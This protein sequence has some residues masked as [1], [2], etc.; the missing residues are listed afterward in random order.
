MIY[1]YS[2]YKTILDKSLTII[3]ISFLVLEKKWI[4]FE[5]IK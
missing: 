2:Y 1:R 3:S 5:S 4:I